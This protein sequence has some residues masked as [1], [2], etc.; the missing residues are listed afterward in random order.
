MINGGNHSV[1]AVITCCLPT[2]TSVCWRIDRQKHTWLEHLKGNNGSCQANQASPIWG[3]IGG[4][5][6]VITAFVLTDVASTERQSLVWIIAEGMN[7][8][9]LVT[10][11]WR[12]GYMLGV[13]FVKVEYKVLIGS[14]TDIQSKSE[15]CDWWRRSVSMW[16]GHTHGN[17]WMNEWEH[18]IILVT[19]WSNS[20]WHHR[21]WV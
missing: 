21:Q 14:S 3:S 9:F 13:M 2:N 5:Y 16:E 20:W 7:D 11:Q 18:I 19:H 1:F 17:E 15:L 12:N 10:M 8:L 6:M 4:R